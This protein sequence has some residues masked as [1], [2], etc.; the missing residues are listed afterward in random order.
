M[1]DTPTVADDIE[2]IIDVVNRS[3]FE[4]ESVGLRVG[5]RLR[6]GDRDLLRS[7][8]GRVRRAEQD[9]YD[10]CDITDQEFTAAVRLEH[11]LCGL[12]RP[13]LQLLLAVYRDGEYSAG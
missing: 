2:R 6:S 13:G 8:C 11:V 12:H 9:P 4:H 7:W 3:K 10:P 1:A 5:Q